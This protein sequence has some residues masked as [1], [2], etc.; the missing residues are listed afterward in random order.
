MEKDMVDLRLE[1]EE[2]EV[3]Q[4]GEKVILQNSGYDLC[5]VGFC[6]REN[7]VHFPALK[8][9]IANLWFNLEGR[10]PLD[11]RKEIDL[12]GGTRSVDMEDDSEGLHLI[13]S[14][15]KKRPKPNKQISGKTIG[16]FMAE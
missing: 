6:L 7:V 14:E 5:L 8:N 10:C 12:S 4:F 1:D 16:A 9:T 15:G 3:L 2:E 11:K 13:N